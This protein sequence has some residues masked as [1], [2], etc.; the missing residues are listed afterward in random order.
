M[1]AQIPQMEPP[2]ADQRQAPVSAPVGA[3]P[4]PPATAPITG[5]NAPAMGPMAG[6]PSGW[7]ATQ[8]ATPQPARS[9][10]PSPAMRL[11]LAIVSLVLFIPLL[12]IGIGSVS[13]LA[14][15]VA[16][17]VALTVGLII[18][19]LVILTI[20]AINLLFNYDVLRSRD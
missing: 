19:A 15:V 1:T 2:M 5:Y 6:A 17:W 10:I 3:P 9:M 12:A 7:Y 14:G 13:T 8:P 11:G 16:P 4:M 18:V 20:V